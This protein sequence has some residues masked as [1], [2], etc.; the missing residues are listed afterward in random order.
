MET[1]NIADSEVHRCASHSFLPVSPSPFCCSAVSRDFVKTLG[2]QLFPFRVIKMSGPLW[3]VRELPRSDP[4]SLWKAS[5]RD[6]LVKLGLTKPFDSWKPFGMCG[7]RSSIFFL[8]RGFAPQ[9]EGW[10][11]GIGLMP[12]LAGWGHRRRALHE[13]NAMHP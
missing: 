11:A 12:G 2:T 13:D 10:L 4:L 7:C 9:E 5:R 3:H 6:S 1:W 8:T